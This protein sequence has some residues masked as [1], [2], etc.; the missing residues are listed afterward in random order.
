MQPCSTSMPIT[1]HH[2]L[3]DLIFH[4]LFVCS[5][6]GIRLLIEECVLGIATEYNVNNVKDALQLLRPDEHDSL[7][8]LQAKFFILL[9]EDETMRRRI[10]LR[11]SSYVHA[12]CPYKAERFYDALCDE[13]LPAWVKNE[14]EDCQALVERVRHFYLRS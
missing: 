7:C 14:Q 3:K 1:C 10:A 6:E 2:P 5:P 11:Q 4:V 9:N 13:I 8:K 12:L